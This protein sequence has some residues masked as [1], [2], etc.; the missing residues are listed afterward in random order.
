MFVSC[1]KEQLYTVTYIQDTFVQKGSKISIEC[2][3]QQAANV[4]CPT[5]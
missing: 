3:L 5:S 2:N 4:Y 1:Y